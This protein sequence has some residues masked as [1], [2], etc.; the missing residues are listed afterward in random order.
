MQ[1]KDLDLRE[2][3]WASLKLTTYCTSSHG[4]ESDTL[5]SSGEATA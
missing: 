3:D 4:F 2:Q 5:N 1:E